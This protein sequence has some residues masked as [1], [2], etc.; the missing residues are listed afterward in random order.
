MWLP[1]TSAD[2]TKSGLAAWILVMAGPKSL[3]SSGKKSVASTS[4][5]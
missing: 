2:M 5:P 3:T 4:P 1:P